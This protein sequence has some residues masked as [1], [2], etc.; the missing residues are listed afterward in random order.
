MA[1][2]G[3]DLLYA[4]RK[5]INDIINEV[6]GIFCVFRSKNSEYLGSEYNLYGCFWS[7]YDMSEN[8]HNCHTKKYEPG[9]LENHC[10]IIS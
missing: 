3:S 5:F 6:N 8:D 2:I 1:S 7:K 4:K 9:L 10:N